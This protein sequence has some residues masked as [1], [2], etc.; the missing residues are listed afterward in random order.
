MTD[1]NSY[2]RKIA[3]FQAEGLGFQNFAWLGSN[4]SYAPVL[5]PVSVASPV[6]NSA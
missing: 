2:S 3:E 1:Q 4:P 6:N 5:L